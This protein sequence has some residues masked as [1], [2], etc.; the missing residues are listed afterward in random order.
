MRRSAAPDVKIL[1]KGNLTLESDFL[2]DALL[3][4]REITRRIRSQIPPAVSL[5]GFRAMIV[6]EQSAAS[7]WPIKSTAALLD[8]AADQL[9]D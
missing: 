7:A 1:E 8:F 3:L 9:P 5:V 4:A 2:P 6:R